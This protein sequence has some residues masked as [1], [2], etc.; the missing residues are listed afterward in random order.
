M[1]FRKGAAVTDVPV[2]GISYTRGEGIGSAKVAK[3]GSGTFF[4]IRSCEAETDYFIKVFAFNGSGS[5]TNYRTS[6]PYEVVI[7][8]PVASMNN[9][10][11][12]SGL[13]E[14]NTNFVDDLYDAINPH[15]VRF[16]SNYDEDMVAGYLARDTTVR[17]RS[18]DLCLQQCECQFCALLFDW[19]STNMNRE[20]TLP[21]SW[22]PNSREFWHSRIPRF[23][24]FISNRSNGK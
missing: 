11:Y 18:D 21:A 12:W 2:D 7:G 17:A 3:S 6:D 22:M 15:N 19:T 9:S 8:T 1:L 10:N 24:S 5:L 4:Q 23:S 14:T 20:H 16:Y 13:D